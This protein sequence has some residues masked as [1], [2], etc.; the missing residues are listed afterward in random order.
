LG[1]IVPTKNGPD[2]KERLT[3]DL[4]KVLGDPDIKF[5]PRT[6]LSAICGYKNKNQIY[7]I[8]NPDELA[9]LERQGLEM[10]RR[11]YAAQLCRVDTA[12][13]ERAEAGDMAAAKLAYQRFEAWS[14]RLAQ[15]INVTGDLKITV[16]DRFGGG[17]DG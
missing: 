15:D 11:K 3:I 12:V 13:F 17:E 1:D 16:V 6:T 7:K 14:E 10:R 9:E 2:V 8:F 4:L 5:P